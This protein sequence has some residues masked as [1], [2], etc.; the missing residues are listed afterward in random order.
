MNKKYDHPPGSFGMCTIVLSF[1]MV[2]I[3][4]FSALA[5]IIANSD[6][7]LSKKYAEKNTKYYQAE[8]DAYKLISQIDNSLKEAYSTCSNQSEY[9]NSVNQIM[10]QRKLGTYELVTEDHLYH[11]S[12][13]LSSNQALQITICIV[14]PEEKNYPFYNITEW[15]TY[16]KEK[17]IS[18][19]DD[20]LNL[21]K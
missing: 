18:I 1:T 16:T 21:I 8:E 6:Y 10:A 17:E 5:L 14:Y 3:V 15:K 19:D 4:V 9:F 7:N 11:F 12:L 20:T 2:C 13:A